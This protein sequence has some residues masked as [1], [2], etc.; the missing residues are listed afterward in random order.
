[1]KV[2]CP[3]DHPHVARCARDSGHRRAIKQAAQVQSEGRNLPRH[4]CLANSV[5]V[6]SPSS[7][8]IACSSSASCKPA[9]Q[10]QAERRIKASEASSILAGM[11]SSPEAVQ[12]LKLF[13]SNVASV[14]AASVRTCERTSFTDGQGS[15]STGNEAASP[16]GTDGRSMTQKERRPRGEDGRYHFAL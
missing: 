7:P 13:A 5:P 1:M 16:T 14:C 12:E 6:S 15:Q 10:R 2:P 9:I 11:S 3:Y 4:Y 8:E